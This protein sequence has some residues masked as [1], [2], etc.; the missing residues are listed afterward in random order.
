MESSSFF[1]G[2]K[3]SQSIYA[4]PGGHGDLEAQLPRFVIDTSPLLSTRTFV[5]GQLIPSD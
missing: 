5:F 3:G 4:F 1:V 2:E